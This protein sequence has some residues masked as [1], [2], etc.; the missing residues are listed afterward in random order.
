MR[1]GLGLRE[2]RVKVMTR[3]RKGLGVNDS[4]KDVLTYPV[5]RLTFLAVNIGIPCVDRKGIGS[6]RAR[7]RSTRRSTGSRIIL[8]CRR[9]RADQL[10]ANPQG[11]RLHDCQL[12]ALSF[13]DYSK[14]SGK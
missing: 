2:I 11:K 8:G 1:K 9:L 5:G 4:P 7:Q 12:M 6:S 13:R 10:Q 3:P 14:T